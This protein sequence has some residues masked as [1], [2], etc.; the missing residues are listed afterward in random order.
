MLSSNTAESPKQNKKNK[1]NQ[2]QKIKNNKQDHIEEQKYQFPATSINI[3]A[4]KKIK[5][6]R[7]V[8]K[9]TCCNYDKKNNYVNNYIKQK[10]QPRLWK[11]LCQ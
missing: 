4:S 5:K 1:K 2:K 9:I 11:F 8:S 7:D 6:R 10:N 3:K